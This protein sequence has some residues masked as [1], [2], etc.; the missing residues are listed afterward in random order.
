MLGECTRRW[1][2]PALLLVHQRM[3]SV[4][5]FGFSTPTLLPTQLYPGSHLIPRPTPPPIR[6]RAARWACARDCVPLSRG[7]RT[8][9][10]QADGLLWCV[11]KLPPV[12]SAIRLSRAACIVASSTRRCRSG[13]DADAAGAGAHLHAK[14]LP[15]ASVG[16]CCAAGPRGPRRWTWG[17][18]GVLTNDLSDDF[19]AARRGRCSR[20][21]G[22]RPGAR[23]HERHARAHGARRALAG[24]ALLAAPTG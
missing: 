22:C 13:T 17:F 20:W 24:P 23:P 12:S 19:A 15:T 18:H 1:T 14:P 5:N 11:E 4:V 6:P 10:V 8:L 2:V 16:P 9:R 3:A 21:Y 7:L